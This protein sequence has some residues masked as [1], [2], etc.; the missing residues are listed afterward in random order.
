MQAH[1]K[2]VL[3]EYLL[4]VIGKQSKC[5]GTDNFAINNQCLSNAD[6][7]M[8][9]DRMTGRLQQFYKENESELAKLLRLPMCQFQ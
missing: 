3:L 1:H 9:F 5:D 6:H 7:E 4:H 2:L 8:H